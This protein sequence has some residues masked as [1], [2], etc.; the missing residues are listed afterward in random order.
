MPDKPVILV[1]RKIMSK[2]HP[3]EFF[4]MCNN[5]EF[6][7]RTT[8]Y[9][10]TWTF[11]ASFS[12]WFSIDQLSEGDQYY[13]GIDSGMVYEAALSFKNCE[14]LL[15]VCLNGFVSRLNDRYKKSNK[16]SNS[17]SHSGEPS[18]SPKDDSSS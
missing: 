17:T 15:T 11:E 4:G 14:Q 5:R 2:E 1:D 10:L 18:L 12:A 8:K 13:Y 3:I 16:K 7:F 9:G 6:V